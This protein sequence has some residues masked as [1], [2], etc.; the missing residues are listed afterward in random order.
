LFKALANPHRLAILE[1]LAACC[2]PGVVWQAPDSATTNVGDLGNGLGIAGSTL[3]HHLKELIHAGLI[4]T[5][6]RGKNVACWL[7]PDVLRDLAEYFQSL[8]TNPQAEIPDLRLKP[9]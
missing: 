4:R 5:E 3:S 7:D 1:R 2:A 9:E 8:L 6:R